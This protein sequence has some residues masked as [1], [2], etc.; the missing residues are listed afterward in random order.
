MEIVARHQIPGQV[1][2][3]CRNW[4]LRHFPDADLVEVSSTTRAAECN[5]ARRPN[6]LW[7]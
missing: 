5:R 1:F 6:R 7:Q 3:Q 2:G 4:I